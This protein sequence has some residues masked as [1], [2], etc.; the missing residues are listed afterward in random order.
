[1]QVNR[2]TL[3]RE[4]SCAASGRSI[5]G[6]MH[7]AVGSAITVWGGKRVRT[8][9]RA[10]PQ[11]VA[12][13]IGLLLGHVRGERDAFLDARTEL[14]LGRVDE[15]AVALSESLHGAERFPPRIEANP[16]RSA[17]ELPST[18]ERRKRM[19]CSGTV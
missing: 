12:H 14:R 11:G 4:S 10:A 6:A 7:G 2:M 17:Y 3:V 13:G 19:Q 5:G 8:S 16:A 9:A 1:M 15:I 18:I